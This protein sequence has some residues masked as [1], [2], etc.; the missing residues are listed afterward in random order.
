MIE[1]KVVKDA[2]E[3]GFAT[4]VAGYLNEGFEIER[5]LLETRGSWTYMYAFMIRRSSDK[6]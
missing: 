4:A 3:K 5:I 6:S 2:N 1:F